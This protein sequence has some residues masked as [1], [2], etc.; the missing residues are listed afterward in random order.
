MP[1]NRRGLVVFKVRKSAPA[2]PDLDPTDDVTSR[3]AKLLYLI[4]T[5]FLLM[6]AD[7]DGH[8]GRRAGWSAFGVPL[9]AFTSSTAPAGGPPR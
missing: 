7:A 8:L 6:R 4:A 5:L 9:L 2:R 3:E 1:A